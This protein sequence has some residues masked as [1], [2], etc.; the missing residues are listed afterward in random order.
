MKFLIKNVLILD[1]QSPY[2]RKTL[3]VEVEQGR[4]G[5]IGKGLTL[6]KNAKIVEGKKLILS[7][8]FIDMNTSSGEPYR[9]EAETLHS[10]LMASARGGFA[11]ITHLPT[12]EKLAQSKS[13]IIYLQ[14]QNNSSICQ[15]LPVG[16]LTRTDSDK[17]LAGLMDMAQAGAVAF[18]DG[19]EATPSL[20]VL[21]N[22][23][24][25]AKGFGGKIMVHPNKQ[26]LSKNGQVNQGLMSV[27]LGYK[28]IPKE[29]E[30]MAVSEAIQLAKYV[31]S[32]LLL[33]NINTPESIK[34][35]EK[36]NSVKKQIWTATSSFNLTLDESY[37]KEYDT[38]YKL[39]PPLR[40]LA[41]KKTLLK[42]ALNGSIDIVYSQHTPCTPE[43]KELEF[44]LANKGAINA[45]TAVLD[46]IDTLGKDNI[47]KCIELMSTNPAEYLGLKLNALDEGVQGSFTLLDLG[48]TYEFTPEKNISK[49]VNSPYFHRRFSSKIKG[50]ISNHRVEFY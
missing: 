4:I 28:G 38:Y 17:V 25:Y 34:L 27:S 15:L 45:Q 12:V 37:L 26:D 42:A 9:L 36:A 2:Y 50:L 35:I 3:D 23:L 39:S 22:A 31:D 24:L 46:C 32:T 8:G 29:A 19:N 21:Q 41:D 5:K 1:K 33:L 7:T 16:N 10:L 47:E 43:E 48:E 44:D 18:S 11:Y 49:S 6:T 40:S 30:F 14:S 13:D 20:S